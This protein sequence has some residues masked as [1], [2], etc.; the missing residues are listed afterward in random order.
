M[1]PVTWIALF[2]AKITAAGDMKG[3][4]PLVCC[5][6]LTLIPAPSICSF[7]VTIF[8]IWRLQRRDKS[9]F[10]RTPPHPDRGIENQQIFSRPLGVVQANQFHSRSCPLLSSLSLMFT[11]NPLVCLVSLFPGGAHLS[12]MPGGL[13][14]V[15]P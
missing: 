2:K 9:M 7:S 6:S 11:M 1:H 14:L 12:K 15:Y 3:T 4:V 5:H 8:E 13:V 10:I